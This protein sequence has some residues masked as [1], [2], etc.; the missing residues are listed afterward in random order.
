MSQIDKYYDTIMSSE[1][2]VNIHVVLSDEEWYDLSSRLIDKSIIV[3]Q[4][5]DKILAWKVCTDPTPVMTELSRLADIE[6]MKKDIETMKS[7]QR[8][9]N[10]IKD[11][12]LPAVREKS[13]PVVL[14][15]DNSLDF[16][17]H[18]RNFLKSYNILVTESSDCIAINVPKK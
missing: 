18:L 6:I 8:V 7:K 13:F 15:C 4:Y 12:I 10:Y 16:R 3:D 17:T 9:I 11:Y 14:F 1:L 2:P 5:R